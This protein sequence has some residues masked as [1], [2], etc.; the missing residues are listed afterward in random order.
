MNRV[1][2]GFGMDLVGEK[3]KIRMDEIVV[4][5]RGNLW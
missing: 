5:Q 3:I 2:M 4:L 1:W